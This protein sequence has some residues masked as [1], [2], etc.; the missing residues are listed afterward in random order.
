MEYTKGE[1]KKNGNKIEVF[2]CGV[3]AQCPA[4]DNGGVFEFVANAQLIASAPE[5]YEALRGILNTSVCD[6]CYEDECGGFISC[7]K[8][9]D[10]ERCQC[11]NKVD[12]AESNAHQA[13]AKAEGK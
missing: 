4:P 3:V 9:R 8:G 10:G 5:L 12:Q 13:L 2:S 6:I 7:N 1:W 11:H